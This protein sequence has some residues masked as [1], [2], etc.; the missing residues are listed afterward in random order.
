M[1]Y[2]CGAKLLKSRWIGF[3]AMFLLTIH[4]FQ[5]YTGHVIRFYQMQQFF[6]LLTVY[7]F[8]RGFVSG[9]N[10]RYRI[11]TI[12]CF[13]CA[14]VSQEISIVMGTSLV[15]GYVLFAKD[16]GW[17][18]N[19][20]LVIYSVAV[21][22]L[23]A[24]DILVFKTMCLTRTEG[25][26][27][28][29]EA[30]ISPHFWFPMN[31][32]AIFIGYSR[33]HVVASFFMLVGLPLIWREKNL[34]AVAFLMFLFSGVIMT[35][36]LVSHVS[37]RYQYWVFPLWI[38][39]SLL[40]L[41]LLLTTLTELVYT[42]SECLNRYVFNIS[43]LFVLAFMTIIMSWSPWRIPGSYDVKILG[44]STGCVR[45][46]NGQMRPGDKLAITEP[47]THSG[48]IESGKVDY[49]IGVPLLYDFAVFQDGRLVDRNGGG[50]LVTCVDD[51]IRLCETE[52][53]VWFLFNREKFRTRGKN[54][55]WEY[56]G[57]RFEL[58]VRQNCELKYR[59]YLW[60][61]YLWDSSRGHYF[62]FRQQE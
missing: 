38:L 30:S 12:I 3:T 62:N 25:V 31:F 33:L 17:K 5:I 52:D 47:H 39:V 18:N 57:S 21:V 32:F 27:P 61:A 29:V 58:F 44:D 2:L 24:V 19:I 4:P 54:M 13:F 53:R 49:D 9:Q 23:I 50:E 11:A 56:P 28:N 14:V 41:R 42:A 6:A 22:M 60:S 1:T 26:S 48:F 43:I 15:L 7:L 36:L 40:G 8:C 45:W 55:R 59:S 46:V 16:L 10:Q 37:L 20:Q 35:N 51:L 34:N